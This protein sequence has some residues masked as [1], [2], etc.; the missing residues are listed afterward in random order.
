MRLL[1]QRD[2]LFVYG[3]E[4]SEES[5][6]AFRKKFGMERPEDSGVQLDESA[7]PASIHGFTRTSYW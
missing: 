7:I 2:F 1:P 4:I 5:Q 3:F 6:K